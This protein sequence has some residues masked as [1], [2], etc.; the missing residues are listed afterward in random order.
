MQISAGHTETRALVF[1]SPHAVTADARDPRFMEPSHDN[2][3]GFL[4]SSYSP[5][6]T[7]RAQLGHISIGPFDADLLRPLLPGPITS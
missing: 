2:I 4:D 1:R 5:D 3:A 6:G 7:K